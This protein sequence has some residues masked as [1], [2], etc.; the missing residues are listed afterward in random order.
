LSYLAIIGIVFL[1]PYLNQLY[2]PTNPILR[3][4]WSI[5]V[6]CL[7]AQLLTFPLS[8][9][10]FHQF[11]TYF[12]FA[13]PFIAL[14]SFFV[15]PA[16]LALLIC[17]KIPVLGIIS[18][19]ILKYSLL[20][21]NS[22][23]L[24]FD[25]IPFATLK[26]FSINIPEMAALYVII[27]LLIRFFLESEIKYL[28][29]SILV[30]LC[31]AIWNIYEDFEQS[32]QKQLVFHFIPKK[33][34]IS[35]LDGKTATFIADSSLIHQ[36]K[37]YDFHLKNFFD[38][39]GINYKNFI[40]NQS[41][42]NKNGMLFL[43]FEGKRILWLQQK[44]KG[45]IEGNIDYLLLSNNALRKLYPSIEGSQIKQIIVDDSNKRYVVENLKHQADSLNLA[46]VSLYDSGAVILK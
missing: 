44:F 2:N 33:S 40:D 26:G 22:I 28:K 12:L 11:P 31:V 20:A 46:L 9:Y 42:T 41:F 17:S 37:I 6:V 38:N 39:Q 13:N 25:K 19:F 36:P 45:K 8:V 16:G 27:F 30:L 43:N 34:G 1:H 7:S 24:W 5:T 15:L 29:T 14:F 4:T 3:E 10:Y 23:I 18:G 32:R 35:I 21:L